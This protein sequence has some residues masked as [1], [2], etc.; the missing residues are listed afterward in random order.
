MKYTIIS[1]LFLCLGCVLCD[2][3]ERYQLRL[4]RPDRLKLEGGELL[5]DPLINSGF[6][7]DHTFRFVG[8]GVKANGEE[9]TYEYSCRNEKFF[10]NILKIESLK[11]GESIELPKLAIFKRVK[12]KVHVFYLEPL[13]NTGTVDEFIFGSSAESM[14][15]LGFWQVSKCM[16]KRSL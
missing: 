8:R 7:I 2:A 6:V 4:S 13:E 14:G 3:Q 15:E 10:E 12:E 5:Y 16:I 11:E 9:Y 1:I